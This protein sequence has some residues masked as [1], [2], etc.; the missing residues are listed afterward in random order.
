MWPM[1]GLANGVGEYA[2]RAELVGNDQLLLALCAAAGYCVLD[3]ARFVG[4][5]R[6]TAGVG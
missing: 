1:G 2:V 3:A 4:A 5:E 6:R